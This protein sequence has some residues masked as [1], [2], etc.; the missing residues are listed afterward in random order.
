MYISPN[1]SEKPFTCDIE[2]QITIRG[3]QFVFLSQYGLVK[4]WSYYGTA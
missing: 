2:L 1:Y 3:K 4:Y